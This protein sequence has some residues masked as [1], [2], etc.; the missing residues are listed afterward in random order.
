MD[1]LY[2]Y[3][4]SLTKGCFGAWTS[5]TV[6]IKSMNVEIFALFYKKIYNLL[7]ISIIRRR[8]NQRSEITESRSKVRRKLIQILMAKR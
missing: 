1:K 2:I 4:V 7:G 5:E 3:K 8:K 6:R